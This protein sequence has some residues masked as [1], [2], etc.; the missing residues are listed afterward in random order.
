[1]CPRIRI[2]VGCALLA[3]L[4]P[5]LPALEDPYEQYVKTSQDFKPVRQ[6]AAFLTT[7]YPSWTFMPWYYQWTIGYD[8]A[9]GA[10][11]QSTGINGAFT[12][13]G[14]ASHLDWFNKFHL[15]FYMDHTA[16]KGDLH[17]WDHFPKDKAGQIHGTGFR[18][19]SVNDALKTRLEDLIRKNIEAVQSSP[20]R[21]AY[22]LDD[23]ISWGHFVH[24]CMW[25][26]TDD[27]AAYTAWLREIYGPQAPVRS[28]WISYS[29]ILPKLSQ[30]SVATFDASPLMDQ[31]TF[32]DS[33]WNNFLG[34]LVTFAN[35]I[36]P[37]T[38]CG[39]VGGQCPNAFGGYDY[40]KLM[41]KVQ[42]LEAY[43][44]AGVQS[45]IRS[46][47]PHNAISTV[48]TFFYV[49]PDD[50]VWQAW[51]YLAQGNRGHIAWV[52]NWFDGTTPNKWLAQV[53]PTYQECSRKI[54]PLVRGAE[55]HSDGVALYYSHA[56]IQLGW[57][58]DAAAH[59]KTWI[60]RNSDERLGAAHLGRLAWMQMLRDEGLQFTWLNYADLIQHGVPANIKV[61]ILPETLC[62]SDS[63]ARLIKAFCQAGGTV[64]ADYLPGLWDQ[65]G[66]G[67]PDGGALDD[68]FGVKHNPRMTAK[69]LFQGTGK[70]WCEVDQ[71]AHFSYRTAAEF[72]S[73]N[74]CILD[75]SGFH[76]AVRA[77]DVAHVNPFGRGSATLLN[78]SPQWYRAYRAAGPTEAAKRAVFMK[79][80]HDA[81]IH[82]WVQIKN[83]DA[84]T[85][86]YEITCWTQDRRAILFLVANPEVA[87]GS[88][89]GGAAAGLK[90][91]TLPVTLAFTRDVSHVKN[92]RTGQSLGSGRE[93]PLQWKMNEACVISFDA[94]F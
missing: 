94:T 55:F 29:D 2:A 17:L 39:F 15:H 85:F 33:Y 41:R 77:M 58:L 62:L 57:I 86:G 60:N 9:A 53:A 87:A 68:L 20:M 10:F 75:A 52:E 32:N 24:P 69:D 30:W 46:F 37:A 81:G 93:F 31:W 26:V 5:A 35:R 70:L 90:S 72:L 89:G 54:G 45:I 23:E 21:S 61:L 40:A 78:L 38:P 74:P 11:C 84:R 36:D 4:T 43:N 80:I 28:G 82:R 7:A 65:H 16:G 51:Y 49:T 25:Q 12:D 92:E 8:D 34:D 71:D 64:V 66:K 19:H 18:P 3:L 91:D 88:T 48:T 56:S 13:R 1:M 59:G 63:E 42:F 6:D 14:D 76:K 22:A 44:M 73:H 27:P 67:R 83:A 47:N 50:A 79:P